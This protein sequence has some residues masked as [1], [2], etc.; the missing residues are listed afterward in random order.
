MDDEKPIDPLAPK[1]ANPE[2]AK[3]AFEHLGK[4]LKHKFRTGKYTQNRE[5]GEKPNR[6]CK[7]CQKQWHSDVVLAGDEMQLG[8]CDACQKELDKGQ[9]AA[10]CDSSGE[11]G[12][13]YSFTLAGHPN[14][15]IFDVSKEVFDKIKE[16]A[17]KQRRIEPPDPLSNN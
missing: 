14:G 4:V 15:P 10:K 17:A 3:A 7:I 12:F 1:I 6:A 9:L 13:F 11:Y 2:V 5:N 8:I 16:E